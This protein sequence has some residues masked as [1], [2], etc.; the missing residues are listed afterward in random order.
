MQVVVIDVE[1]MQLIM[2]RRC[3][4]FVDLAKVSGVTEQTLRSKSPRFTLKTIGLIAKALGVDV[5][6]IAKVNGSDSQLQ[7]STN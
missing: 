6:E 7:Q 5:T 4:G 3:I 2:A 1:K